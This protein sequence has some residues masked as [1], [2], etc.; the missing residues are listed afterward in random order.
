MR[1]LLIQNTRVIMP[2]SVSFP[3]WVRVSRGLIAE[4]GTGDVPAEFDGDR[5]DGGGRRLTPGL[6]DL[7]THGMHTFNYDRGAA[8]LRAAAELLGRYGTTTVIPTLVPNL[9][10]AMWKTLAEL[11]DVLPEIDSVSI[12][13]LHLEGPFVAITGA[14]CETRDGDLGLLQELIT[15]C[16]GRVS[17]MSIAPEVPNIIPVIE[18]LRAEGIVPFITHTRA[19]AE[20]TV[21][22]I[23]AGA[24]HATHFY[25]VFPVPEET[26]PGVRPVGA[27]ETIFGHV[28]ATC[29][30]ICDGIHVHPMAIR[31]ALASKGFSGVSLITDASF[32]AGLGPGVYETP[33]GYPVEVKEGNAPRI[34]DPA[35]PMCG[36][37]AGSALTMNRG[38]QNLLAWL[39][40][41][42]TSIWAMGTA[43][44]ARVLGLKDRGGLTPD[45][46][47]DVVLWEDGDTLTPYGTWV[48]G[49]RTF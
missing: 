9:S 28:D 11:G 42:E 1:D 19:T 12:P 32:G 8:D 13:G 4:V 27:V 44:P 20:Q 40:G 49:T 38:M 30:F 22:A 37:L 3:G 47:A 5:I 16:A 15:A 35:H 21:A 24:R 34:A 6:I 10:S 17:I 31:A 45:M 46:R 18:H 7:H 14:A 48:A 39:Q 26:D 29:D 25:D 23:D 41:P 36:A 2:G 43:N 33:W